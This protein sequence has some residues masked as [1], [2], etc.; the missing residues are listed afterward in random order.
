MRISS[1][2]LAAL[3]PLSASAWTFNINMQRF[4]EDSCKGQAIGKRQ[5]VHG[6]G[7]CFNFKVKHDNRQP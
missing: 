5:V 4:S 1:I 6:D 7:K 2:L 3:G